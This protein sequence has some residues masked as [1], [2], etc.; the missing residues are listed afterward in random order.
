MHRVCHF[1]ALPAVLLSSLKTGMLVP[2]APHIDAP[3]CHGCS[4][5]SLC[6]NSGSSGKQ[7]ALHD[8]VLVPLP[9]CHKQP[10]TRTPA[11]HNLRPSTTVTRDQ[12]RCSH[13]SVGV[14]CSWIQG[15]RPTGSP[16]CCVF[17]CFWTA[18][19][20]RQSAD[21]LR[22]QYPDAHHPSW[23]LAEIAHTNVC[24]CRQ[25]LLQGALSCWHLL[26]SRARIKTRRAV[27]A[28][29]HW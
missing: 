11:Q 13:S 19:R 8:A 24:L 29:H 6:S 27:Q 10:G 7:K 18:C 28:L 3:L 22:A 4:C 25:H 23:Q 14:P 21:M 5:K 26:L 1:I 9:P 15:C 17:V 2:P 12:T 20:G 16:V